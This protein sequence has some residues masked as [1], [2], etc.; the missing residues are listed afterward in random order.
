MN[1]TVR[2]FD[3][4]G[5]SEAR[6]RAAEARFKDVLD[7]SL[8]DTALVWPVRQAYLRIAG[9]YG[10]P[11]DLSALSDDERAVAEA[12]LTAEKAALDAVLGPLRA[13][14]DGHYDLLPMPDTS[15]NRG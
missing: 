8:G 15:D 9:Q 11:P 7:A 2:L 6:R 12:W 4:E 1:Y 5:E 3:A 14:G 10:D 13:M